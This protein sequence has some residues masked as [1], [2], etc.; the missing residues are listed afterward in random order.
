MSSTSRTLSERSEMADFSKTRMF[1]QGSFVATNTYLHP[2]HITVKHIL[3]LLPLLS[4]LLLGCQ[5]DEN[6][7]KANTSGG[8]SS[9]PS[10]TNALVLTPT[11]WRF[12]VGD[13]DNQRNPNNY[14]QTLVSS[15][16]G[17]TLPIGSTGLVGV[18]TKAASYT[19]GMIASTITDT[20]S[21][22]YWAYG[23]YPPTSLRVGKAL[24]LKAKL[25]LTDVQGKGVSLVIRGDKS[26]KTATLFA[27]TQGRT[28]IF[29]TA[30][31]RE[32]SITMPYT[33]AVDWLILYVVLMPQTTGT[34]QVTDLSLQVN[35]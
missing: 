7:P 35:G 27:S 4:L 19:L 21:Y 31:F 17:T 32:Y 28:P 15:S 30:D 20:A 8:S 34:V 14:R 16:T 25:K 26:T 2:I 29:G 12:L 33:Q 5:R 18:S 10:I 23:L 1:A 24:T 9:S 6:L 22:C 3:F 13:A 11:V